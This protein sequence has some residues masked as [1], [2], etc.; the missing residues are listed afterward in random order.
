MGS[1]AENTGKAPW[2]LWII[3]GITLLFNGFGANDYLQSQL[4]N[5]DYIESMIGGYDITVDQMLA[6]IDS[7]PAWASASWALGVWGAVAGSLLLLLRSRFAF[8]AYAIALVGLLFTTIYQFGGAMPE[9]L[10]GP[11][12]M[13]FAAIIWIVTLGLAYYARRMSAAG[14]LR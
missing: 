10:A 2:H 9:Q 14:V 11:G 3:G 4:R 12:Q 1:S 7:F 5:R 6:Y 8:Y 13:V